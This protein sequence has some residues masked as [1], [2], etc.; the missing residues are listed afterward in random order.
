MTTWMAA[1]TSRNLADTANTWTEREDSI[2]HLILWDNL[3]FCNNYCFSFQ[4]DLFHLENN[5]VPKSFLFHRNVIFKIRTFKCFVL[6]YI[7]PRFYSFFIFYRSTDDSPFIILIL[8]FQFFW[9]Q[10]KN[11]WQTHW[12]R[13]I[14]RN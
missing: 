10:I 12:K 1:W 13:H 2:V 3:F 7:F 9:F 8:R 4:F 6:I 14:N 5:S 11:G